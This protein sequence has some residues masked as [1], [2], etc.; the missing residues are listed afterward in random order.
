MQPAYKGGQPSH[1]NTRDVWDLGDQDGFTRNL[2]QDY[3][4]SEIIKVED[5]Q[6]ERNKRLGLIA[7]VLLLLVGA[8]LAYEYMET[9]KVPLIDDLIAMVSGEEA[10]PL[11]NLPPPP[12]KKGKAGSESV[13]VVQ[14]GG[15][16]PVD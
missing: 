13:V 11:A 1:T 6:A 12:R 9:G 16:E 15:N 10:D 2:A 8:Y 14:N 4:F 3:E 7:A 5:P